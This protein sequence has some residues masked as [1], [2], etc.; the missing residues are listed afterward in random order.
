[1]VHGRKI[2]EYTLD[3]I[4]GARQYPCGWLKPNVVRGYFENNDIG[5]LQGLFF[6]NLLKRGFER[7]RW[8]LIFPNQTAGLVKRIPPDRESVDEYHIR[9]YSDGVIDCELEVN[10]FNGWHW[11]G[12]R[13]HGIELLENILVRIDNLTRIQMEGIKAQFGMKPYS[14]Y[15]FR[16]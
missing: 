9:F 2:I 11:A 16:K 14:D 15:C 13:K 5:R 4:H 3:L 1:M 7:T 12:S 8:Q 6:E 10:R